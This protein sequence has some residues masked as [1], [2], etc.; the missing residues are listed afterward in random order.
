MEQQ[1]NGGTLSENH[2]T[3]HQP[4]VPLNK[5]AGERGKCTLL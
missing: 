4:Q 3:M 2:V 1:V 5:E